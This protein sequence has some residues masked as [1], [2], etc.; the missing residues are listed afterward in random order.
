[1]A[2]MLSSSRLLALLE[3][4][5]TGS[6]SAAAKHL[7]LT[8]SAVSHQISSLERQ[9]ETK[10]IERGPRGVWLT[11]AGRR[12]SEY[13][14]SIVDLMALAERETRELGGG[15][16]GSLSLGFFASAGLHLVP[17]ALSTFMAE[18]P[19]VELNLIPGQPHELLPRLLSTELDVAV[20]FDYSVAAPTVSTGGAPGAAYLPLLV[21]PH[22][23]AVPPGYRQRSGGPIRIADLADEQWIATEG[24]DNEVALVDRICAAAGYTPNVRCRTDYYDIT[25]GMVSAGIGFALIPALSLGPTAERHHM[26]LRKLFTPHPSARHI[27]A[28]TRADNPNPLVPAFLSHLQDSA[29]RIGEEI[30]QLA[31]AVESASAA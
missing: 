28:A 7:Q 29:R 14:D 8:P 26:P 23:L 3:V 13:S 10:L 6:I 20:V 18:R 2:L 21:D 17:M 5:R 4:S 19:R 12:L 31:A 15:Q 30:D 25:L 1:M 9:L 24:M 27:R 22:F 16:R 11:A